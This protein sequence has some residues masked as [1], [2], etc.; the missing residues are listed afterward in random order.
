MRKQQQARPRRPPGFRLSQE[1]QDRSDSP[2]SSFRPNDDDDC[3]RKYEVHWVEFHPKRWT[4]RRTY[5]YV[6]R[7]HVRTYV[8]RDEMHDG[9]SHLFM[10]N[11]QHASTNLEQLHHPAKQRE[12]EMTYRISLFSESCSAIVNTTVYWYNGKR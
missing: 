2:A 5:L 3:S 11:A 12:R 8:R 4:G 10:Q 1:Q 6:V 7:T 9:G